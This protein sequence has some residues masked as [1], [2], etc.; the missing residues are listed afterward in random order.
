MRYCY[1][2]IIEKDG[3]GWSARF[4]QFGD[5]Q[6]CAD[7]RE[8]VVAE[9]ADLLTLILAGYADE[10]K[11]PPS[12]EHVADCLC[13]SVDLTP[14]DVDKTHYMT[15]QEAAEAL[16]VSPSRVSALIRDGRLE[17]K[18][19]DRRNLVSI[20]SVNRCRDAPRKAGRPRK[21]VAR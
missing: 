2:A 18:R 4:P 7:T 3:D 15:Q 19:F 9:A 8:D 21:R 10:G 5:F 16:Q 6:T 20:D 14:D 12:P 17:A 11:V 13:V 1:E